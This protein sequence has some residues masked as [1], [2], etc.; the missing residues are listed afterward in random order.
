MPLSLHTPQVHTPQRPHET[1][2]HAA[3]PSDTTYAGCDV[4]FQGDTT[5]K[6]TVHAFIERD[7]SAAIN[8]TV[9]WDDGNDYDVDAQMMKM[10]AGR[11]ETG[12]V[13][14][15]LAPALLPIRRCSGSI[16]ALCAPLMLTLL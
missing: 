4:L 5:S 9:R 14:L 3:N 16:A 12:L 11:Y 10:G 2:P 6:I 1:S 13:Y 7:D 15:L 8:L